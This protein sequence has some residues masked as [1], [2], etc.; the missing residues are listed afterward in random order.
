MPSTG[1]AHKALERGIT[2]GCDV[3]QLFVK[4]NMIFRAKGIRA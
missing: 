4:K 3:A 2:I 1:G